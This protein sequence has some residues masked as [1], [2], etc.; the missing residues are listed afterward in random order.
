MPK[1]NQAGEVMFERPVLDVAFAN[2]ADAHNRNPLFRNGVGNPSQDSKDLAQSFQEL[3]LQFSDSLEGQMDMT[4]VISEPAFCAIMKKKEYENNLVVS[5][6]AYTLTY[7]FSYPMQFDVEVSASFKKFDYLYELY[8]RKK[9]SGF[10]SSSDR[11]KFIQRATS[12][13]NMD[14]RIESSNPLFGS[15]EVSD[16]K[17]KVTE[18]LT[19][20]AAQPILATSPIPAMNPGPMPP[21]A[22]GAS[23]LSNSLMRVPNPWAQW[24]GALVGVLG[25]TFGGST[26]SIE[27][28]ISTLQQIGYHSHE[29]MNLPMT[30]RVGLGELK[31]SDIRWGGQ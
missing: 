5:P 2:A 15:Q 18:Y 16:L 4:L 25:A 20:R 6:E 24:T 21:S 10:F 8:E 11:T 14:I 28:H 27:K 7:F 12:K 29:K 17:Q 22:Q 30:A 31:A 19:F 3:M 13:E 26:V 1:Y 23:A 9:R